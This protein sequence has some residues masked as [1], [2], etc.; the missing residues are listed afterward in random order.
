M[1][2]EVS[3]VLCKLHTKLDELENEWESTAN[4]KTPCFT[5]KE[6]DFDTFDEAIAHGITLAMEEVTKAF[7]IDVAMELEG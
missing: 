2:T 5:L 3:K 6:K 4:S 1:T 7:R